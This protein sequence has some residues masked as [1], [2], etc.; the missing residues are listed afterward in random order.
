MANLL[1]VS[2]QAATQNLPT[3]H[4]VLALQLNLNTVVLV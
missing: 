3:Y 2:A 4:K 1:Q